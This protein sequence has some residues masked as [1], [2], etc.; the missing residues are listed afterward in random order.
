MVPKGPQSLQRRYLTSGVAAAWF[1]L[2]AVAPA[3]RAG[4]LEEV[5]K[6]ASIIP[7]YGPPD[8]N[9]PAAFRGRWKV[10]VCVCILPF[11]WKVVRT[12]VDVQTPLGEISSTSR[13]LFYLVRSTL[14]QVGSFFGTAFGTIGRLGAQVTLCA[15][16]LCVLEVER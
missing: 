15:D 4:G 1:H 16:G 8:V 3:A 7:G 10:C 2:A 13:I 12:V 11:L 9:Y 5:R 6:A 14:C